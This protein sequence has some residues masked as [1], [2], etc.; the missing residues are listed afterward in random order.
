MKKTGINLFL[1]ATCIFTA[2]LGGLFLGRNFIRPEPAISAA[3]PAP[4]TQSLSD[5]SPTEPLADTAGLVNINTATAEELTRLPGI[6]QVLA[7]RI[8]DYRNANGPFH[9][10]DELAEVDGIG[11]KRLESIQDY[12]IVGGTP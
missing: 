12:I 7:Q 11:E 8:I 3:S 9:S 10:I 2:F 1:S 5:A 6:G 4:Q